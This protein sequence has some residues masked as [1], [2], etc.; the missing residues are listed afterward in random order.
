M[1][2]PINNDLFLNRVA[3]KKKQ[4]KNNN[5][6]LNILIHGRPLMLGPNKQLECAINSLGVIWIKS[7]S[8]LT[9]WFSELSEIKK[10]MFMLQK[11]IYYY[12]L[13]VEMLT[14]E[15]SAK[16]TFSTFVQEKLTILIE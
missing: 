7:L 2:T 14:M 16:N 5:Y 12:L 4:Q 13:H 3:A 9:F 6:S 15:K 10:K 1:E 8:P 11:C